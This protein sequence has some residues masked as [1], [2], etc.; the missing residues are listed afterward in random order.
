[1]AL[2]ERLNSPVLSGTAWPEKE[3]KARL[4]AFALSTKQPLET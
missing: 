1:M 4:S 3:K 2:M